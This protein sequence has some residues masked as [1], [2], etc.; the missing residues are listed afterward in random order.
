[1]PAAPYPENE[2]ERLKALRS[3]DVM[4]KPSDEVLDALTRATAT[5]L[6][7]S[8]ALVS[9]T[10]AH[11]QWFMSR[12][13]ITA[14]EGPRDEAFCSHLVY[15]DDTLY[16]PDARADERTHDSVNVTG[17][18][19]VRAYLGAPLRT[20]DGHILG[21]LCVLDTTRPREFT[22][23]E[24]SILEHLAD[25]VMGHLDVRQ[26]ATSL[27]EVL[28]GDA[29]QIQ[30]EVLKRVADELQPL[31][32]YGVPLPKEVDELDDT[33]RRSID[34]IHR[35]YRGQFA[36][37]Q[38]KLVI[39][40]LGF[41]KDVDMG[42]LEYVLSRLIY[43]ANRFT[44]EGTIHVST[45]H[46]DAHSYVVVTD[47]GIGIE[48]VRLKSLTSYF[49][50]PNEEVAGFSLSA[51]EHLCKSMGAHL[52]FMSQQGHGTSAAIVF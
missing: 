30:E 24:H 40:E 12:V 28:S 48:P 14:E 50:D 6:G 4:G 21:A 45:R 15:G 38:N 39:G 43:N 27:Q 47:D 18:F 36:S 29:S 1:M 23:L 13:G 31:L 51:C 16:V 44:H 52:E 17:P 7:T 33:L 32:S 20:A 5:L 22:Q 37:T 8:V 3:Y 2:A 10:G 9:L 46:D 26:A 19:G 35:T 49:E 41:S 11:K 25:M 42:K 34:H